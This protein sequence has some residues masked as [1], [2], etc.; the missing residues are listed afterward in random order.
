MTWGYV[1]VG[2]ATVI[3]SAI[4]SKGAKDAAKQ[5]QRGVQ[6]G[7][8]SEERMFEKSLA[9]QEPYREAGYDAL[10]GLQQLVDPAG[11][12]ELL[13]QYYQGPEYAALSGQ[14]EE[15]QLRNAAATGGLR[16]GGNQAALA[17]IA[18][19]LGQQ[20]LSGLN[21]QYTGLANMGMGAASQGSGQAMQLGGNISALQQQ[22]AQ[23]G[24]SNSLAQA[25]IW[26][27]MASDLGGMA[28]NYFNKGK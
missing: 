8:A 4:G 12:T 28:N 3:G 22:A 25:N 6:Q 1:A 24:A 23:A 20:Y 14:V 2:A 10:G 18:P 5:Q 19:Q 17:T 26:G 27:N 21:Q 15:Q 7:I 16:G 9:L 13:N 11:R